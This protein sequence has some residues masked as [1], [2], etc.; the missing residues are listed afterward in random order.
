MGK[1]ALT[2]RQQF[3]ALDLMGGD[4]NDAQIARQFGVS[5]QTIG[6]LRRRH[7]IPAVPSTAPKIVPTEKQLVELEYY[8]NRAMSRAYGGDSRVWGRIRKQ[9]GIANYRPPTV[10]DGKPN[11]WAE[12]PE[13]SGRKAQ[14]FDQLPQS[15][16][17]PRD[18]SLAGEAASH[19]RKERWHCFPRWKVGLGGGWQVGTRVMN[20]NDMIAFAKKKGFKQ[21]EW[22]G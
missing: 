22:M 8:S 5:D 17:P 4:V 11:T 19:L 7:G 9:H 6:R 12:K 1:S 13:R 3:E 16:I 21:E 10:I 20:E 14:F 18:T 15:P 2:E